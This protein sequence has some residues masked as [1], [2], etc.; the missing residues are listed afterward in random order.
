EEDFFYCDLMGSDGSAKIN[1]LRIH[2]QL[3]GNLVNVTPAKVETPHNLHKKSYE[4]ELRHFLGAIRGLHPVLST[5]EE[6]V[7]R[8]AIVDAAYRSAKKGREVVLK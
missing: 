3:H 8:M 4:N 5:G 2:K 7:Q 1:P 6:A